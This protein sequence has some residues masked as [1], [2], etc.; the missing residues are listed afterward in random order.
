MPEYGYSYKES[1]AKLARGQAHDLDASFKDLGA[2][3]DAIRHKSTVD[4]VALLERV[5]EGNWPILYKKH[6]K[7]LGHRHE[8]GGKKGRYPEKSAK[9]VLKLLRNVIANAEFRGLGDEL[10]VKHACANKQMIYPRMAPKGRSRRSNYETARVEIVI[11]ESFSS[12]KDFEAKKGKAAQ[13]LSKA[14]K[15]KLV[16]EESEKLR[17]HIAQVVKQKQAEKK[18]HTHVHGEHAHSHE[19]THEH[20]PGETG[21]EHSPAHEQKEQPSHAHT[22]E[23][24]DYKGAH[25]GEH[26]HESGN[27]P[28]RIHSREGN[29][30]EK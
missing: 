21:Q 4:A 22:E 26:R 16:R 11:E 20:A 2:V 27:D 10:V 8:L 9:L 13:A 6:N 14:D 7:R 29:K 17:L 18:E 3:C 15:D 23:G 19:E 1:G 30:H 24:Q 25:E 5:A 12:K 28:K